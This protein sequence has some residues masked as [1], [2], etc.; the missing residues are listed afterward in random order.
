[1]IV[2]IIWFRLGIGPVGSEYG[3][4]YLVRNTVVL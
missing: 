4:A 2:L 3:S 1:M